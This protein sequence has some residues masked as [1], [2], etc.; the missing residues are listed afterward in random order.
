M[1]DREASESHE[2]LRSAQ[3]LPYADGGSDLEFGEL[4]VRAS[5]FDVAVVAL[6]LLGIYVLMQGAVTVTW[7]VSAIRALLDGGGLS[8]LIQFMVQLLPFAICM[9]VGIYLLK[10]APALALRILPRRGG[11]EN[12]PADE[13]E[14]GSVSLQAV[15]FSIAGAVVVALAVPRFCYSLFSTFLRNSDVYSPPTNLYGYLNA[16]LQPTLEIAFGVWL[17]V[18]SRRLAAYWHRIRHSELHPPRVG[19]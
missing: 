17:F 2:S 10:L 3:S 4:Y 5:R 14:T 6:R 15:G 8:R 11:G 7:V 12:V 9:A 18:G 16:L 1:P 19:E 13:R